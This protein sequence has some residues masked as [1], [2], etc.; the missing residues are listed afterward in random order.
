MDFATSGKRFIFYSVP[1]RS[2]KYQYPHGYLYNSVIIWVC[3]AKIVVRVLTNSAR[4]WQKSDIVFMVWYGDTMLIVLTRKYFIHVDINTII[5]MKSD[6]NKCT[7]KRGLIFNSIE[8]RI[9]WRFYTSQSYI[10]LQIY[11]NSWLCVCK[12]WL[13]DFF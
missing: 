7:G 2:A 3:C 1:C 6:W 12:H 10:N 8:R 13:A 9:K 4:P 5:I 11:E